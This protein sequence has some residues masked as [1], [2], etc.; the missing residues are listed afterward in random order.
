MASISAPADWSLP[1]FGAQ[2]EGSHSAS[3][4]P[5]VNEA[6]P[7]TLVSCVLTAHVCGVRHQARGSTVPDAE[8][9]CCHPVGGQWFSGAVEDGEPQ[10]VGPRLYHLGIWDF[11]AARSTSCGAGQ[12]PAVPLTTTLGGDR[13]HQ[14]EDWLILK[15]VLL[16]TRPPLISQGQAPDTTAANH[17]LVRD[18]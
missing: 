5:S 17:W 8:W 13:S 18:P 9:H 15:Q 12:H 1:E 4:D 10:A 16:D 11:R 14:Q 6:H 3:L 2:Q 7:P